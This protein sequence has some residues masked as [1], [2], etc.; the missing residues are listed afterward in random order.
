[1]T[2]VRH[3]STVIRH[4]ARGSGGPAWWLMTRRRATV[5]VLRRALLVDALNP[6]YEAMRRAERCKPVR[7]NQL[8]L[9]RLL[10]DVDRFVRF[11]LERHRSDAV[12]TTLDALHALYQDPWV[13]RAALRRATRADHHRIRRAF[14]AAYA[15]SDAA[16]AADKALT[17]VVRVD[18]WRLA[19]LGAAV[20]G[21]EGVWRLQQLRQLQ[22]DACDDAM[23]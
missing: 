14:G 7:A 9:R 16:L 6:S 22:Q 23:C 12:R 4:H 13:G 11:L 17:A 5:A 8:A 15:V 20:A 2:Y 3:M 21:V 10:L 18:W 1:M 19:V